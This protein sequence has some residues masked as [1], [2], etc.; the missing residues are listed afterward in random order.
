[1]T[2]I[3]VSARP[4]AVAALLALCEYH[5]ELTSDRPP[6]PPE[7]PGGAPV[8]E[9]D[10]VSIIPVRVPDEEPTESVR[11]PAFMTQH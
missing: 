8:A 5:A 11:V 6:R 2:R 4:A 3:P 7:S 9:P 10:S 1:M